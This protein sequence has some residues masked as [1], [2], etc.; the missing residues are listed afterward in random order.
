MAENISSD[1]SRRQLVHAMGEDLGGFFHEL[2]REFFWVCFKWQEYENLFGSPEKVD[3]LNRSAPGF[4]GSLQQILRG[5]VLLHVSRLTDAPRAGNRENLSLKR[6]RERLKDPSL[7]DQ[8]DGLLD[9]AHQKAAIIRRERNKLLA[10]LDE[11]AA[12]RAQVPNLASRRQVKDALEAI[13][14]VMNVINVRY[15]GGPASYE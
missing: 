13:A 14:E 11:Q 9:T 10:H 12:R 1:E 5:D 4:F 7:G 3:L 2:D 8:I 15:R 6:L